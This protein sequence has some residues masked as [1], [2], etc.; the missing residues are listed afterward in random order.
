MQRDLAVKA[1]NLSKVYKLYDKPQDRFKETFHPFRKKYHHNFYALKDV[2]FEVKKGD[3]IGIVGIN[4]AG[5]S[6]LLQIIYNVLT[7]TSGIIEV[8]GKTSALLELGSGFNPELSGI[9]NV[10]YNGAIMGYSKEEIDDK[11]D[12]ILTFADIG[13]FVN[14]PVKTYSSGMFVRLAFSVAIMVDPEI[15]IIDEALAVGDIFFQAKCVDRMKKM[16]NDENVTLFFVSHDLTQVKSICQ[17][18]ILLNNGEIINYGKS[19]EVV[20]K[21]YTS[22]LKSVQQAIFRNTTDLQK[23]FEKK[24]LSLNDNKKKFFEENALFQKKAKYQRIQNG[25]ADIVNVQ[26]L[27]ENEESVYFVEYEQKV[28]LRMA[29]EIHEDIHLLDYG[30][31]IRNENG[32]EVVHS[33]SIIDK[34]RLHGAKK[35]D[36]Y[37]IDWDFKTSLTNIGGKYSILT[38]LVIPINYDLQQY[39]IC[40][41]VPISVQFE[42][43]SRK[44]FPLLGFVHW[45]NKIDIFKY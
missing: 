1:I 28:I 16:I 7:P 36:R 15:L 25:K 45:D 8:N 37:L 4:G 30:Y 3:T 35:G 10:Y 5:K 14:Q 33:D 12:T 9:E 41:R 39:E 23:N 40:D 17:K 31:Q 21:Y 24:N 6:T 38:G 26:L 32:V 34:K 13:E 29:I 2:S 22:Q 20:E 18:A 27:D 19:S 11:L 44:G 42:V 43:M